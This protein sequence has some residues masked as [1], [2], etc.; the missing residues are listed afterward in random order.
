MQGKREEQ[1]KFTV[2]QN[3]SQL[4]GGVNQSEVQIQQPRRQHPLANYKNVERSIISWVRTFDGLH[5]YPRTTEELIFSCALYEMA[6]EMDSTYFPYLAPKILKMDQKSLRKD[7]AVLKDVYGKLFA[8]MENWFS[9]KLEEESIIFDAEQIS[10]KRLLHQKD[11]SEL[12]FLIETI[13]IV[14]VKGDNKDSMIQKILKL[15]ESEQTDLQ[16]LM[17]RALGMTTP[18]EDVDFESMSFSVRK[19]ESVFSSISRTSHIMKDLKEESPFEPPK[20]KSKKEL[21]KLERKRQLLQEKLVDLEVDN[22]L[23]NGLLVDKEKEIYHLKTR[24]EDLNNEKAHSKR[25]ETHDILYIQRVAE[26][27][28][29][30]K[31]KDE[32]IADL[33]DKLAALREQKRLQIE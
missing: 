17:E 21:Q 3:E 1:S 25:Q 6:S 13:L 4:F 22:D 30:T 32:E 19:S 2:S 15:Q 5:F 7:L 11:P 26:L 28:A 12:L 16:L 33:T 8:N 23:L 27:E 20:D 18:K 9:I 29:E 31:F 14:A 24:I 10:L